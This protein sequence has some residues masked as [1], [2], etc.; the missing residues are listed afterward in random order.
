MRDVCAAHGICS[1]IGRPSPGA[2]TRACGRRLG[3]DVK[4]R[5]AIDTLSPRP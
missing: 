4:H 3:S 1:D 2:I 5:F